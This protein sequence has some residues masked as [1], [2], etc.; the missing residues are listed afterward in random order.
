MNEETIETSRIVLKSFRLNKKFLEDLSA[1]VNNEY[2][3]TMKEENDELERKYIELEYTLK[4]KNK[5]I[6]TKK[7][8]NVLKHWNPKNFQKFEINFRSSKKKIMIECGDYWNLDVLISGNDSIWVSGLTKQIEE[9]F[10]EYKSK[11]EFFHKSKAYIIYLGIPISIVWSMLTIVAALI[12][13]TNSNFELDTNIFG[14]SSN[15]IM[16]IISMIILNSVWGWASLFHWLFPKI[17]LEDS[18][19]P[20]IRKIVLGGIS[21]LIFSLIAGGIHSFILNLVF[22]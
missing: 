6:E 4:T 17:E 18:I 15:F 14:I 12:G 11:N 21:T 2:N 20:K 19:Q 9:I 5:G 1:I 8:E 13:D 3:K 10:D 7:I 22:K 16:M